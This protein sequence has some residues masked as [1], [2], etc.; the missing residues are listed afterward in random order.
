MGDR[1]PIDDQRWWNVLSNVF[2]A[3]FDGGI[4][5]GRCCAT[6]GQQK[7]PECYP[8]PATHSQSPILICLRHRPSAL[9]AVQV[10]RTILEGESFGCPRQALSCHQ[11]MRR[12]RCTGNP[13]NASE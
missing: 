3:P 10:P 4:A 6:S 13:L 7:E 9:R 12:V 1:L 2:D 11:L 8:W 5:G